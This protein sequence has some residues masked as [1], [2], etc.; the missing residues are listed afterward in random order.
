MSRNSP[1]TCGWYWPRWVPSTANAAVG[2]VRAGK[3]GQGEEEEGPRSRA[4]TASPGPRRAAPPKV[5]G[6]L[7]SGASRGP[8]VEGHLVRGACVSRRRGL[9]PL[10]IGSGGARGRGRLGAVMSVA[11]LNGA[12]P[13]AAAAPAA[14]RA[15]APDQQLATIARRAAP[16]SVRRVAG[17]VARARGDVAIAA[18]TW[19]SAPAASD[20]TP[21]R[22]ARAAAAGPSPTPRSCPQTRGPASRRAR[23]CRRAMRAGR[24]RRPAALYPNG[25]RRRDAPWTRREVAAS[26]LEE[27]GEGGGRRGEHERRRRAAQRD[28][29][30]GARARLGASAAPGPKRA[31]ARA[32]GP[33]RRNKTRAPTR[34][35]RAR[36]GREAPS[37]PNLLASKEV[38]PPRREGRHARRVRRRAGHFERE[39]VAPELDAALF[40]PFAPRHLG[41]LLEPLAR[42]ERRF[43]VPADIEALVW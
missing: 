3:V 13:R 14:P 17:G 1:S 34:R 11:T 39:A 7:S 29:G 22:R 15:E 27:G 9:R 33:T 16:V 38:R 4:R 23:T 21:R 20:R 10:K 30:G 12:P 25:A 42:V 37:K 31:S 24:G 36:L 35:R 32:S 40:P 5:R 8:G 43:A 18:A 6:R 19:S 26:A 41:R 2:R 28:R